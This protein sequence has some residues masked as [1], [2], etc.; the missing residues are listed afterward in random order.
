MINHAHRPC[1]PTIHHITPN[2]LFSFYF[3]YMKKLITHFVIACRMTRFGNPMTCQH[4]TTRQPS[5][6]NGVLQKKLNSD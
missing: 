5:V 2:E 1:V 3:I 6:F 4:T